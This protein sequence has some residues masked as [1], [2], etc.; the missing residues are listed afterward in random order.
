MKFHEWETLLDFAK[1]QGVK[2]G[3]NEYQEFY[4]RFIAKM[5]NKGWMD[6]TSGQLGISR[7]QQELWWYERTRPY[8]K[9]WPAIQKALM[10][11]NLDIPKRSLD[12]HPRTVLIRFANG[13]EP[14]P[15]G[16][17]GHPHTR[18]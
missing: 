5:I 6:T 18:S 2:I 10:R 8:Y 16:S 3:Q 7:Q 14:A 17:R 15:R 9:V 1:K 11:L 12:F 4:A 13:A